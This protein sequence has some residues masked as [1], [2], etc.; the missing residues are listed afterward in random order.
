MQAWDK[1]QVYFCIYSKG[2]M[3]SSLYLKKVSLSV[4]APGQTELQAH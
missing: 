1:E 2:E 3:P 4:G